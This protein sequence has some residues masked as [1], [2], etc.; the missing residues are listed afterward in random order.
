MRVP[1]EGRECRKSVCVVETAFEKR[2]RESG[3]GRG[4]QISSMSRRLKDKRKEKRGWED[5]RW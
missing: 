4:D 5:G 3:G 1:R 2:E